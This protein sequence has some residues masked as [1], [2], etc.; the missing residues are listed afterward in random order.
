MKIAIVGTGIAGMVT[1]YLLSQDHQIEVYEANDY[2]GGHTHTI[3]VK[4][5]NLTYPVDTGFVVFNH[6][7]Y[8]NFT[9][10]LELLGVSSEPTEMS[11]SVRCERSGLEYNGTSLNTLFAQRTNLLRPRFHRMIKD[12]LRFYREAPLL[13]NTNEDGPTLGEFLESND[14]SKSFVK[15]HLIPMGSAIWSADPQK[16]LSFP[17]VSFVQFFVNH[18]F[19]Q[20]AH[21]PQWHIIKGG[22][23][24]YVRVLTARY[25]SNIRLNTPV[26]WIRRHP[27]HVQIKARGR[28][29]ENFDAVVLATHS[30]QAFQVLADPSE[31]ERE[32]LSQMPYQKNQVALHSDASLLPRRALAR[33]SWNYHLTQEKVSAPT[34]TYYMNSLQNL[35]S[36]TDFCVTLNRT[37]FIRPDQ[38]IK[39]MIYSHPV[40]TH[41]SVAAQRRYKEINGVNNTY[42]CGAYW[43]YGFHEDGVNS[44]LEVGKQFGVGF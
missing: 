13:L 34:V 40:F 35:H 38:I 26:K 43:G 32:I 2:V 14:Y 15:Q 22:S 18:G 20:I 39:E 12:I 11:F 30:D 41:R 44:A 3:P 17:F 23:C 21:R 25:R 7:T 4:S 9:R 36:Q 6:H 42:Y 16:M 31:R 27:K 1:G 8:P 28:D 33:A 10:L 5:R 29:P 37:S 19:M 24:E